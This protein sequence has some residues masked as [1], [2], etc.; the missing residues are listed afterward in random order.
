MPPGFAGH[1]GAVALTDRHL[2]A[3]FDL[4]IHR[5]RVESGGIYDVADVG[6]LV[7]ARAY[8]G[9]ETIADICNLCT[10]VKK[11]RADIFCFVR[12]YGHS[13]ETVEQF[14]AHLSRALADVAP[15]QRPDYIF[16]SA[17]G[18]LFSN[19]ASGGR[20]ATAHDTGLTRLPDLSTRRGCYICGTTFARRHF[21]YDRLCARCG[22]V[23]YWK[24]QQSADL[25]GRIALVT[26]A[27]VKI[28]YAAALKLLRAGAHV[29]VTT[30]FPHD[31]AHRY[32]AEPDFSLWQDRLHIYGLDMRDSTAVQVFIQHLYHTL[33][34]LDVLINN[35]AQTVRRPPAFYAHLLPFERLLAAEL[36]PALRGL[37][38]RVGP[39]TGMQDTAGLLTLDGGGGSAA[40]SQIPRVPGDDAHDPD[41][42]PPDHYDAD[43]QQLDRRR[44]N[45]WV[46]RLEEVSL[47]E[48]LEVQLVNVTA[49]TLLV[50]GL[51]DLMAR[52]GGGWIVNVSATEGQFASAKQGIHPHTNMAKAAL[53][54]LV[55]S[56]AEDY[57]ANGIVMNAVDPGWV[58][59]QLPQPHA[60]PDAPPPD[61]LPLDIWDGAA[62]VC[63]PIFDSLNTGAQVYGKFL[64]NYKVADW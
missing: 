44:L 62:R 40:L 1:P 11:I 49:P 64:K 42:F 32:A 60:L 53:N 15:Q 58:S 16:S 27:R 28:G 21:F 12:L 33:P 6:G 23:N 55:H 29:V 35:A 56:C 26:G 41:A 4:V 25:T 8:Q 30:R 19:P 34:R 14:W 52:G 57:A 46:T 20:A 38:Y 22:D 39:D 17:H 18:L 63:D 43:G 48:M 45:S 9:Q 47:P 59:Q 61:H 54:M 24:R 7:C 50:A 37:V 3:P 5:D 13:D 31:A 10:E 2:S 36:P 51:K